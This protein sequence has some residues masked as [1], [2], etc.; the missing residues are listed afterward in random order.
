MLSFVDGKEHDTSANGLDVCLSCLSSS[1]VPID[2]SGS[3][4]GF[5]GDTPPRNK[6][7]HQLPCSVELSAPC[8]VHG[9][10]GTRRFFRKTARN[11]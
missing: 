5:L 6:K 9:D 1:A 2:I 3:V 7:Y 11:G 10:H 8:E 4:R